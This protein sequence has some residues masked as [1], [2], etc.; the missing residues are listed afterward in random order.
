MDNRTNILMKALQLFYEKGYDAIGVQEIADAAGVTKPT[1]YHYYGSKYGLLEAVTMGGYLPLRDGLMKAAVYEG[2]LPMNLERLTKA[3]FDLCSSNEAYY[4]LMMAMMYS[5][6]GS[7]TYRVIQPCMQE[8]K[9]L[10]T[11]LFLKAGHIIGNMR[12]RQEQYS[13]G[14]Y[15]CMNNYMLFWFAKKPEDRPELSDSLVHELVHQFLYGIYV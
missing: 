12:G 13:I 4:K 10:L 6:E 5:A 1:L 11:D 7:D 8:I 3:Y 15:G 2:D 14:F 9:G